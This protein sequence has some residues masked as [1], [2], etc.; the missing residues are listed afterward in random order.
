MASGRRLLFSFLIPAFLLFGAR[1]VSATPPAS[2]RCEYL[3]NP[4]G[5]DVTRP[6]FA[7]VL[8]SSKRGEMQSAYQVLVATSK[9]LLSENHGDQ[10]DSGKVASDNSTQVAYAGKPLESGL[11]YYWKVRV[12]GADG[13]AS[14][15]S[16]TGAFGMGL[17]SPGD[18]Q[19]EWI[20]GGSELRKKFRLSAAAVRARVYITAAGYYE[21]HIN[22]HRVGHR[23]LDPAFTNY[24]KRVLYSTYDVTRWLKPGENAIGVMLGNGWATERAG[25][26]PGYFKAPALLAQMNI[27]LAGGRR[28]SVFTDNSWKVHRGPVIRDSVYNGE[29]YDARLATPGWDRPGFDD[30]AWASAEK[31]KAPGGVLSAEMMPPI[32]VSAALVPRKL[33]NPAPGVYVFDFGQNFSG[34]V[35]LRVRGPRGTRVEMRFAEMLYPDGQINQDNLGAA[36]ARDVY[37]LGG[38]GLES[39]EPR[40][41]YHGFR[42]V[43]VT[44]FPGAPNLDS[45]RGYFVHSAVAP[46]GSF[47]ASKEI[48]NQ[49]QHLIHWGQLSNLMSIPTDC[50]QRSERQG[51][52]G[53]AQVTAEEAMM[54]FDMAAFYTNF[55]RDIHD[56]QRPDGEIPDTVPHKY[57]SYPADPA[58]GTAYPLITWYM[59]QQYG[60]RRILKEQYEGLKKWVDYLSSRAHNHVLRY[61]YYGDWVAIQGTPGALVSDAYYYYDTRI[62]AN[63]AKVL[64]NSQD[65]TTYGRLAGEIKGAFNTAFYIQNEGYY[66]NGSQTAQAMPL[67]LDLVPKDKRRGVMWHLTKNILYTHNTH[68]TTGFIGIKYLLPVLSSNGQ[69]GLAYDLA[70]QKTYPSWGYMISRGATT[71]WELWQDKTGSGMN[72]H[73]HAMFGSLGSWMYRALGGIQMRPATVGYR[74]ILIAPEMVAGLHWVEASVRTIRGTVATSWV[75]AP[76]MVSLDVTIPANSDAE[77]VIPL[78]H[79][80][81]MQEVT[82]RESGRGVWQ[83]GHY[84]P[85]DPGI[86]SAR[87]ENGTIIFET[88][89]GQYTFRLA[90]RAAE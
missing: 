41:T 12:W 47:V 24:T 26:I 63:I 34:W 27:E 54:N 85:G 15:Y 23:V 69:A 39:Y 60:D 35:R 86:K 36:K 67:F 82:V 72:S 38:D 62:V 59:W 73:N 53:D 84:T 58:W 65:A 9:S 16:R 31:M 29:I 4:R 78:E 88:G 50:D 52:M 14:A 80:M 77:I 13:D 48:L 55:L 83:D 42:Y 56:A 19:G 1:R 11:T 61:S 37:I 8:E 87:A 90:G 17:L 49:I 66:A 18:W 25:G 71:L 44:G 64:G 21:L 57:G 70:T 76:G 79:Q 3:K 74:H 46:I 32:R 40:F 22:G 10:W 68:V 28:V 30:S 75:D 51:W 5:I 6:R 45:L 33:T 20:G 43:E 7:W 2:L 81:T 89:S